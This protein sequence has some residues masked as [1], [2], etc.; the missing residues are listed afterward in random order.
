MIV[1][2]FL[3]KSWYIWYLWC[4][5]GIEGTLVYLPLIRSIANRDLQVVDL[6]GTAVVSPMPTPIPPMFTTTLPIVSKTTEA[7]NNQMTN[8]FTAVYVTTPSIVHELEDSLHGQPGQGYYIQLG[9]G[10]PVQK[11]VFLFLKIFISCYRII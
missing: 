8:N 9:I 10:S 3:F 4:L 5:W 1:A 7:S 11:V 6:N 2:N